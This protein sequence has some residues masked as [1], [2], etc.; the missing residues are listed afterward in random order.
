LAARTDV[1]CHVFLDRRDRG[2]PDQWLDRMHRHHVWADNNQLSNVFLVP[3]VAERA[4]LD[5]VIY[6]NF[7]PLPIGVRHARIPLI[8]DVIFDQSP[9]LFTV[10]ERLYFAPIRFLSQRADRVAT[11]SHFER[12]RMIA[13]G[14]ASADKI[15]VA[16]Y[17]LDETFKPLGELDPLRVDS[18]LAALD[19]RR[20]Y[21]LYVGRLTVRKNVGTLVRA[22][23]EGVTPELSLV[24]AGAAD[25]TCDDLPALAR[26]LGIADRVKF[27][28]PQG[29]GTLDVLYAA[30]SM[31]CF[32]T[33]DESFGLPPLEAM[34]AGTPV[35]VSDIEVER[36]M[37]GDAALFVAHRDPQAIAS[38]MNTLF[39]DT[40]LRGRL[41]EAGYA[42]VRGFTWERSVDALVASARRSLES[43]A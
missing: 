1:E 12:A 9:E 27:I 4:R 11:V 24:V 8:H 13:R 43:R 26:R 33:L 20:P 34:M 38:G 3:P 6:Q 25:R 31:F 35:L 32:P 2:E 19:I 17:G 30:A 42:R 36:E 16:P 23:A 22:M 40:A 18:V 41:I 21:A 7:A 37:C 10:P 5:A 14:F 15:D 28:G 29:D 39:R